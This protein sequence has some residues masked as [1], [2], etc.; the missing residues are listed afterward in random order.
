MMRAVLIIT[1]LLIGKDLIADN[2]YPIQW[3]WATNPEAEAVQSRYPWIKQIAERV[4]LSISHDGGS[5]YSLLA[6]GVP[7]RYGTNTWMYTVPDDPA[8]LATNAKVRVSSLP[9]YGRDL[10]VD[11]R[12]I[13]IA[14]LY[15]IDAP[16]TV[17]NGTDV[18]LQWVCAGADSM[19]QLGTRVVGA[20]GWVPQAMFASVDSSQGGTTNSATWSVSGLQ[21][22]PTEIILQS[23]AD[24]LVYSRHTLEVAP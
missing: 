24:P 7:S 13:S 6:S 5:T 15:L 18:T 17:T 4:N 21:E 11:A 14:G 20:S 3:V 8:S 19:V 10:T 16:G 9:M 12:D 1:A 2:Q 22:V 23:M